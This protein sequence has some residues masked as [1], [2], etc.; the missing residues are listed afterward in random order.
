MAISDFL[1]SGNIRLDRQLRFTAEIDKMTGVYRRTMLLSKERR[2]NDAEHSWHIAVM[3]LLFKEY[4]VEE[5]SV[6][7][8]I[9]MLVVHDLVEIY[10]GDTFAYDDKG[11]ED[12]EAREATA[13]DKLFSQIPPEQGQEIRSLWEEFDAMET[14]DSKYAACLDRL[15]PFLHNTL[16]E[17]FTWVESGTNRAKVE[18]RMHIIKEFMPEVYTWIEKNLDNAVEKGWLREK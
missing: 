16:T 9:K 6:E 17:G 3:A 5:P 2:E 11:N 12:K 7:R 18:K 13:A 1:D 4:C 14:T 8:A 10:A 15:Q